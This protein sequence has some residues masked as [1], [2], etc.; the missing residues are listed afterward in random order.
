MKFQTKNGKDLKLEKKEID[1]II[2]NFNPSPQ[3]KTN[4]EAFPFECWTCLQAFQYEFLF[5]LHKPAGCIPRKKRRV[6]KVNI[7]HFCVNS[8]FS[9]TCEMHKYP[10]F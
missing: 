7:K 2:F 1:I 5:N 10:I 3:E 8:K 9:T 6:K 4:D